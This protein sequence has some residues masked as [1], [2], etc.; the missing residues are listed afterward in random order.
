MLASQR[1]DW[2]CITSPESASVFLNAWRAAG[3]PAGLRVA[4]VG[5][6]TGVVLTKAEGDAL[7]P[8][9]VPSAVSGWSRLHCTALH[10]TATLRQ[11]GRRMGQGGTS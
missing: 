6:G 3:R 8:Q 7:R 2:I 5:E 9:F 10:C 1:F 4:V 11:A